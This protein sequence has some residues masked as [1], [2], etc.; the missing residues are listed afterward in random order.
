MVVLSLN[1]PKRTLS[2]EGNWHGAGRLSQEHL[3][4]RP[5]VLLCRAGSL[6]Y[7]KP[8]RQQCKVNE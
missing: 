7:L 8:Q 5:C 6:V 3:L 4:Y 1:H 2:L